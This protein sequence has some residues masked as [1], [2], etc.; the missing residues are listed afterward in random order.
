MCEQD[1]LTA[2]PSKYQSQGKRAG[3]SGENLLQI[4]FWSDSIS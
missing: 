3:C 1:A 4:A 2:N